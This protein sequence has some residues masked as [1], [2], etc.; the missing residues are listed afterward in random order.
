M[1]LRFYLAIVRRFWPLVVALPLL[2]GLI[3]LIVALRESPSYTANAVLIVTQALPGTP[4]TPSPTELRDQ[5]GGTEY[6]IDDLSRVIGSTLFAQDVSAAL[7]AQGVTLDPISIANSLSVTTLHRSVTIQ[8]SASAP[9]TAKSLVEAAVQT[10]RTNGL[11]YWGLS[12]PRVGPGINVVELS[13]PE[14]V[15]SLRSTRRLAA[16]IGL[17]VALG[18]AAGVG[19]AFLLHYLDTTLHEPGQVEEGVGLSVIGVIPRE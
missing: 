16:T 15:T 7:S 19:I 9:E 3:S 1:Q 6:V 11:K 8:G 13:P 18:L 5:W 14:A 17:R 2:V 10:L 12:G 4:Y